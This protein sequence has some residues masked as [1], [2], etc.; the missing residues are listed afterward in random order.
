MK[1]IPGH[2]EIVLKARLAFGRDLKTNGSVASIT[3]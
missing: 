2:P 1:V 3:D